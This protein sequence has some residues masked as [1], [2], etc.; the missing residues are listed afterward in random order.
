M[1]QYFLPTVIQTN[2]SDTK[3][4]LTKKHQS[5]VQSYEDCLRISKNIKNCKKTPEEMADIINKMRK[6]KLECENK[7][8]IQVLSSVPEKP[9]HTTKICQAFTLSGKK[10]SF[11][12]VYGCY[13]KK[14]RID[15]EVLGTKPKL[16]ISIL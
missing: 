10:C 1:S 11:K 3:N 13:C 2:F 14:H 7:R 4:I 12:A 8:P 5:N 15:D 16:N 9:V 6:R